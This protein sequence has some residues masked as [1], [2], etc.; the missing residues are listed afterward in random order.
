MT[1][2]DEERIALP[3]GRPIVARFF[4]PEGEARGAALV[5]PA[6]GVSQRFYEAFAGW[7]AQQGFLAATF[8]YRGMGLSRIGS[9]RELD[10]D[11]VSWARLDCT[12]MVDAVTSRAPGLPL[13][14]IGHSLGGQIVPFVPNRERI[15]KIVTVAAGS[16]YWLE[17]TPFLRSYVWWLWFVAV[18]VAVRVVGYFPGRTLRKVGDLPRGCIEQWRRWCLHREYAVGAE[19]PEVRRLYAAVE[20]PILSLSFTDDEYMSARNIASLHGFYTGAPRTMRRL[21]P[22]ELGL[23]RVGHF[24]FFRREQAEPLWRPYLLPELQGQGAGG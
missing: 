19:G 20:T 9:L 1:R 13:T 11:L 5:V 2:Y 21:A 8:D 24:G 14:W 4:A 3:D 10:V 12:A 15:A 6:M 18:P 7:L 22:R 17:N 23:R 16:G